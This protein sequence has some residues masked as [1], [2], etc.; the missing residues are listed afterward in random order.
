MRSAYVLCGT[1]P[2]VMRS[3]ARCSTHVGRHQ[4]KHLVGVLKSQV[5]R[6][7]SQRLLAMSLCEPAD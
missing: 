2:D 1:V 6:R 5:L 7:A 3:S 4:R